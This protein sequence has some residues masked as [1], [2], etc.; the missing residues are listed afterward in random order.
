MTTVTI[1]VT[2]Q[3]IAEAPSGGNACGGDCPVQRACRR[4]FGHIEGLWVCRYRISAG[5]SVG[6]YSVDQIVAEL[7][8]VAWVFIL[9]QDF[10]RPV[11]PFSFTIDVDDRW[12]Q[13][14]ANA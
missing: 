13:V 9:D 2:A 5:G 6:Q 7:P 8:R 14:P 12:L 10:G 1:N 4:P 11:A 3:D